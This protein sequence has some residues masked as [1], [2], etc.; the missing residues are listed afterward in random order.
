MLG[1]YLG[2]GW[3][4]W[5]FVGTLAAPRI[6]LMGCSSQ[7]LTQTDRM[8]FMKIIPPS[9]RLREKKMSVSTSICIKSYTVSYMHTVYTPG[10]STH[11]SWWKQMHFIF[12]QDEASVARKVTTAMQPPGHGLIHLN[13]H[14]SSASSLHQQHSHPFQIEVEC[15]HVL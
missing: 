9:R 10:L 5:V 8:T 2:I 15:W 3:D 12:S 4:W 14:L 6:L 13:L 7:T 11:I 1:V